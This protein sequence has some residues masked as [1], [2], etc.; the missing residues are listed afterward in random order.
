MF[1]VPQEVWFF[2]EAFLYPKFNTEWR[3]SKKNGIDLQSYA[4]GWKSAFFIFSSLTDVIE[5]VLGDKGGDNAEGIMET[6]PF[7]IVPEASVD[8]WGVNT[9]WLHKGFQALVHDILKIL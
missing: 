9:W 6:G 7:P 8:C 2:K 5:M 3:K 4:T 1:W